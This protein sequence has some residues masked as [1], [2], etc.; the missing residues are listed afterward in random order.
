MSKVDEPETS[1]ERPGRIFGIVL[2][3][4]GKH[5]VFFIM[6]NCHLSQPSKP[7]Y[8]SL[9][10]YIIYHHIFLYISRCFYLSTFMSV[11]VSCWFRFDCCLSSG[12]RSHQSPGFQW[13]SRVGGVVHRPKVVPEFQRMDCPVH[14]GSLF[15]WI[16]LRENLQETMVFTIKYRAFL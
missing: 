8:T 10:T 12:C 9:Y 5:E 11:D 16:G 6:F 1:A 13:P 3:R 2:E 4:L 14:S 7:F 15:H